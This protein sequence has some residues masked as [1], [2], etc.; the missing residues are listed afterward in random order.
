MQWIIAF[1]AAMIALGANENIFEWGLIGYLTGNALILSSRTRKLESQ[2]VYLQKELVKL[3]DNASTAKKLPEQGIQSDTGR[4]AIFTESAEESPPIPITPQEPDEEENPWFSGTFSK[5]IP[6]QQ[7]EIEQHPYHRHPESVMEDGTDKASLVSHSPNPFP[8]GEE[9]ERHFINATDTKISEP[10]DFD[11]LI[12][13]IW[14]WF[15]DGNTFVRV[16]IVILF[17]GVAFLLNL[18]ID[19]GYIP[20]ELRLAAVAAVAVA[21]LAQGW[22]LQATR[23]AYALL[24]QGGAIGLLYLTIFA[25]YNLYH[26]IPST[27]AFILLVLIAALAAA[28]AVLQNALSLALFGSIGGFLAPILTSSGTNNYIGLFSFYA[29]LNTGI[30]AIAW[31]KTWRVLNL[32]GFAFTFSIGAFWGVSSY[33]PENFATAEPFLILFFLFYV[34]IAILYATRRAPDFKDYID[35]TL[36]F[37]TPILAFG[38]QAAMVKDY[39]YG[40]AISAFVLGAFYLTLAS[41]VWNRLGE[42]LKFLSETLLSVCVIFVTLAVPFAM[43]GSTT[44]ATWAVESTGVLWVSIR[45]QHFVRRVFAL[46][47]QFCAGVALLSDASAVHGIAFF[48]SA[49]IGVVILSLCGGLSSWLLSRDFPG[50]RSWEQ[51]LSPLLLAY[52]LVWLFAGFNG[53]IEQHDLIAVQND[54]MLSLT[55]V[56]TIL[57]MHLAR[58]LTWTAAYH[59]ALSMLL[60]LVLGAIVTFQAASHPSAG[61]GLLLW[62]SAFTVYFLALKQADYLDDETGLTLHG[63]TGLFLALLLFWEGFW[64]LLLAGSLLSLLCNHL[65]SRCQWPQLRIVAVGLFPVM[66][67]LSFSSLLSSIHPFALPDTSMG[68]S[69]PFEAGFVLWP[70]AFAVLYRLFADCERQHIALRCLPSFRGLSLLLL[71]VLLTWESCRHLAAYADLGIGWLVALLPLFAAAALALMAPPNYWPFS[72]YGDDYLDWAAKPLIGGL[73]LWSVLALASPADSY[74]LPWLP[75]INPAESAQILVLMILT[76]FAFLLPP[77]RMTD[78]HKRTA[79]LSIAC[80]TFLWLNFVLLRTIHHWAGLAWSITLLSDPLTQTCLSIFWTLTGLSLTIAATRKQVRQLW[81]TGAVLLVIVVVKLF[82]FDLHSHDSME[83]VF[84]FIT[85]GALLMLIGYFAPLPPKSQ[86]REHVE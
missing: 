68:L 15:T 51:T 57:L 63:F 41:F 37:G 54:L 11:K 52:S 26:L 36:N 27:L 4:S 53:Q 5:P 39:Q 35:G 32:V 46:G 69:W 38:L 85:V 33:K 55:I 50:R 1:I 42:S 73:L 20:I 78:P 24:I 16:G 84:S 83:R 40:V 64:Q 17:V 49:F 71:V 70:L 80:F 58:R 56:M 19:R 75:L 65:A 12:G 6:I 86:E 29:V 14:G 31:F 22:R 13:F 2:I 45:Q 43:D 59:A 82:L 23:N 8:D 3:K 21:L 60:P 34:G 74:P 9:A 25:G 30:F 7:A 76:R 48:N 44:S 62:P 81:I 72:R 66:V 18:A 67:F 47:L 77:Q 61:Y 10:S 79:Y 28:L